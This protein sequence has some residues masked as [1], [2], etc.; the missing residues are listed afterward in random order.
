MNWYLQACPICH[1]DLH[2]D[3][4]D[5][6]WITC[7]MCGRSYARKDVFEQRRLARLQ[8]VLPAEELPKVA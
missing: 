7:F 1:G 2:D 6:G 5:Q 4:E 3:L 8:P